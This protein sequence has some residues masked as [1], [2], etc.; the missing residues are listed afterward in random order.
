MKTIS[1]G[2]FEKALYGLDGYLQMEDEICGSRKGETRHRLVYE[3]PEFKLWIVYYLRHH[4]HGIQDSEFTAYEAESYQ[5]CD[6]K[7]KEIS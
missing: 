3:D 2:E 6:T 5:I 4:E 7:Y 1:R